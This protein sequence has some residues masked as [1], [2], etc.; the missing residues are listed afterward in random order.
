[1]L[2]P[3]LAAHPAALL[4]L[5]STQ[6]ALA[7]A[8]GSTLIARVLYAAV[9]APTMGGAYA[10]AALNVGAVAGPAMGAASLATSAGELGP[11]WVAIGL[12]AVT[13]VTMVLLVRPSPAA[14]LR[15]SGV[16]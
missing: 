16:G 11:V 9:D 15:A 4:V 14:D 1:M 10:T 8:V 6:G 7:F 2:S 5:V 12:T 13:L 3:L